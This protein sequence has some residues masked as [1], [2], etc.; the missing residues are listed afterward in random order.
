MKLLDEIPVGL[1][2]NDFLKELETKTETETKRL[3]KEET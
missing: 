1:N 2:K 3:I